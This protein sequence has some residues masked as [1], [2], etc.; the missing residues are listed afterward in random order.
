M[1][2][3]VH[4]FRALERV[5]K[6]IRGYAGGV[7]RLLC[8]NI[9]IVA[10]EL[11]P[12]QTG[13]S[14]NNWIAKLGHPFVGVDGS[15]ERPSSAAQKAGLAQIAAEPDDSPRV[16]SVTNNVGYVRHLNDGTSRQAGPGWVEAAVAQ[17]FVETR[18]QMGRLRRVRR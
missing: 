1:A 18:L 10:R 15:R 7:R 16:A 5:K 9:V 6:K 3:A 14:A 17:A 13:H 8:T 4:N 2:R 12:K 11:N